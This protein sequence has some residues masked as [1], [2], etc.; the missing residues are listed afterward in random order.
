MPANTKPTFDTASEWVQLGRHQYEVVDQP[1]PYLKHELGALFETLT[2]ADIDG[3]NLLEFLSGKAYDI[4]RIFIPD[5]MPRWEWEGF[6]TQH[7]WEAG[8]YDPVAARNGPTPSQIRTAITVCMKVSGLDAYK[9]LGKIVDPTLLKAWVTRE[10]HPFLT[11]T[12]L[13]DLSAPAPT[14]STTSSSP[15]SPTED[16]IESLYTE[17]GAGLTLAEMEA[18]EDAEKGPGEARLAH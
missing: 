18:Q 12:S 3:A 1:L 16:V 2:T 8:E 14:P 15:E 6:A 13:S 10:L 11:K 7:A 9:M 4:I 5:L 17:S